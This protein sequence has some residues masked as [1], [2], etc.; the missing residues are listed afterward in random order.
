MS[1]VGSFFLFSP[2][3]MA[4]GA[5]VYTG[6]RVCHRLSHQI[7]AIGLCIHLGVRLYVHV[8]SYAPVVCG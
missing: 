2:G 5:A 7:S 8:L 3:C 6:I 1:E 4:L